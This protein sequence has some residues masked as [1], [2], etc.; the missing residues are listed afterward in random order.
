M[1]TLSTNRKAHKF[2]K[3]L[4]T[5]EAGI[6][7][8]GWE[9][10]SIRQRRISL[11]ESYIKVIGEEAYLINAHIPSYQKGQ[12]EL[13]NRR[14]RKLLLQKKTLLH[15]A[16]ELSKGGLTIIPLKVY[17]RGAFIKLEVALAKGKYAFEKRKEEKRGK[18]KRRLEVEVKEAETTSEW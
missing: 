10:K 14:S 2:F 13:N 17:T 1:P 12:G 6:E 3:L 18:V 15:L 4:E 9:V 11:G 7:L 16:H 8:Q 5:Y